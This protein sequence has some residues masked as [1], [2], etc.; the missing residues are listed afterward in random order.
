[1][2][3]IEINFGDIEII[4]IG[5]FSA[6]SGIQLVCFFVLVLILPT[7]VVALFQTTRKLKLTWKHAI[8]WNT[9][10]LDT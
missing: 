1:M 3:E 5:E 6:K 9:W 2:I 4:R 10:N 7:D 8:S